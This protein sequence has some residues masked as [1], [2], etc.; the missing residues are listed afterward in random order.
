MIRTLRI[1]GTVRGYTAWVVEQL[2]A[3][4]GESLADVTKYVFDQW[5]D[6]N[7]DYLREAF[8]VTRD[9]FAAAER[10]REKYEKGRGEVIDMPNQTG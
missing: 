7:P 3:I 6:Q 4:K 5:I 1:Q 8:G 10:E 2:M 9:A